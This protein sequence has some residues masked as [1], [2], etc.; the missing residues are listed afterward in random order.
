MALTD[1]IAV[2]ARAP[3]L[4][5]LDQD[6]LRLLAF[7]AETRRLRAGDVLFRQGDRSDGA[8]VVGQGTIRLDPGEGGEIVEVGPGSLIGQSALFTRVRRPATAVAAEPSQVLRIPP[9][10]IRRVLEEFPGAATAIRAALAAE[11]AD[12]SGGLEDLR[13]RLLKDDS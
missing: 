7:A 5:L 11:L 10:L 3:L 4:G 12:L 2:L 9:A 13:R 1:D 8:Y 6:A